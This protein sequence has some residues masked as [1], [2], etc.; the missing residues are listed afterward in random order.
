MEGVLPCEGTTALSATAV[1]DSNTPSFDRTDYILGAVSGLVVLITL[2]PIVRAAQ[3]GFL[4]TTDIVPYIVQAHIFASGHLTRPAPPRELSSFFL[5]H[6]MLECGGREFS[7]QP[8][9]ASA[10]FALLMPVV[11][12]IRLAPPVL[13]ALTTVLTYF[14]VR[15]A[16][17]RRI[18]VTSIAIC[19]L[20]GFYYKVICCSAH[21]YVPSNLFFAASLLMLTTAL[22]RSDILAAL[23]CGSFVGLQFTVRPFTAVLV[24]LAMVVIGVGIFRG[25]PRTFSQG[26]A[27]AAGFSMGVVL[28]LIHNRIVTHHWWPLAFGLYEPADR[29]GFGLR[30]FGPVRLN[31]T[32]LLALKNLLATCREMSVGFFRNYV[33]LIPIFAWWVGW[34]VN[35]GRSAVGR[36]TRWDVSLVLLIALIIGGHTAYWC[37]RCVNY[38][39]TYPLFAV[40]ISRGIWY[41]V[42]DRQVLRYLIG[43]LLV[44]L[45]GHWA[46]SI[47]VGIQR[48]IPP[49]ILAAHGDIERARREFGKLLVFLS[50]PDRLGYA[51]PP[52]R[53][54]HFI[55]PGWFNCSMA[56]EE[57][58]IFA[59][60]QGSENG[61]LIARYP[62]RYPCVLRDTSETKEKQR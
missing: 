48:Q 8:P 60:N 45:I 53:F 54:D 5:T 18:A 23:L 42:G 10:V 33:L 7:R 13:S 62:D 40:L 37:P 34:V 20:G 43:L 27:F 58:V 2:L 61:R 3:P 30:G 31:H 29:L 38:F 22:S 41:V 9:G 44:I 52:L 19:L 17:D 15:R 14:W 25:R 4:S 35:R 11:R 56:A 49:S 24:F 46:V 28:L 16:F 36:P 26:V 6:G 51:P 50:T 39:E 1:T 47:P 21:S 32:P 12:D 59:I 57:P 55:V